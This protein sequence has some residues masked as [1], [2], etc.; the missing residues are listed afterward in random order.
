MSKERIIQGIV[1]LLAFIGILYGRLVSFPDAIS[2]VYGIPL[3]WG[4]HQLVS[5]VGP[6]DI[7]SVNLTYLAIDLV[8]WLLIVQVIST[9]VSRRQVKRV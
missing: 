4:I 6:V 8:I 3:N 1:S 2:R 7:W 9:V 5:I